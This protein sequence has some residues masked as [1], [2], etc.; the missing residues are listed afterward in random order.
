MIQIEENR[1]LLNIA[2]F[3]VYNERIVNKDRFKFSIVDEF[4]LKWQQFDN[5]TAN[6]IVLYI[7]DDLVERSPKLYSKYRRR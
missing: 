1:C 6:K 5:T 2:R 4:K 3:T 7:S